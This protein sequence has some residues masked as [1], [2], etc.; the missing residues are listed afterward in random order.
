MNESEKYYALI[1]NWHAKASQEDYFSKFMFE[2]LAFVA[3]L[4]TQWKPEQEIRVMKRNSG[5]ITD[6]DYIQALKQD[7][8]SSDFWADFTLRSTKDKEMVKILTVLVAF[9]KRE[10]LRSDDRWWN[11]DG[12]DINRR[13]VMR[14]R[15]GV[16]HGVGDFQNLVEF[17]YSVRN[18]LFHGVK[19]PS[20]VRDRELVRYAF[21]TLHFF[22]EHIL[23]APKELHRVYPA[24]WEDF[25]HRFKRGEAEINTSPDGGA[26]A[27]ANI[28]ELAFLDEHRYPI[29]LLDKCLERSDIIEA[30]G[31]ELADAGDNTEKMW[32]DLKIAAGKNKPSLKKYFGGLI[33]ELN[34]VH[35]LKLSIN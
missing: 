2:Y 35:K 24:I 30:I 26:G 6:R 16:V 7:S 27:A 13:S 31:F 14:K 28:Y 11:Y 19:N 32:R 3:Y 34:R 22:V 1:K 10:P 21:L 8:Y 5:K 17:W 23:L 18:N 4:R 33:K 29:L 12:F 15:A 20:L 9:L 25:W